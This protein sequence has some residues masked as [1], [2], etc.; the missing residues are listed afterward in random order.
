M[1]QPKSNRTAQMSKGV[2]AILAGTALVR[3][4]RHGDHI[5]LNQG[6]HLG[7]RVREGVSESGEGNETDGVRI[8]WLT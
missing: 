2:P 3:P 8:S 5:P 4:P 7:P 6:L 1:R